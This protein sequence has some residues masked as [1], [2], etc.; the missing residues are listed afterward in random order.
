MI[1][2]YRYHALKAPIFPI[3]GTIFLCD[4]KNKIERLKIIF[5]CL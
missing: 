4:E 5:Q 2:M 3:F 1:I